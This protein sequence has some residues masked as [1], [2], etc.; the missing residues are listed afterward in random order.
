MKKTKVIIASILT[1]STL[2]IAM[3][4]VSATVFGKTRNGGGVFNAYYD[5]SVTQKGYTTQFNWARSQWSA[6][7]SKVSIGQTTTATTSTDQY[8]IGYMPVSGHYGQTYTYKKTGVFIDP[9]EGNW[10]YSKIYIYD[11]TIVDDNMKNDTNMKSVVVHEVGHSL[12]LAHTNEVNSTLR[13]QSVMT[14]GGD[15]FVNY[16]VSAPSDYDKGELRYKWGN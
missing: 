10:D 3:P 14:S 7:S 11:N 15:P 2:V 4:S 16:N 8:H 1:L 13:S 9:N 6:A 5:H 12:G